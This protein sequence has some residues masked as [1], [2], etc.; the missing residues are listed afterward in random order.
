MSTPVNFDGVENRFVYDDGTVGWLDTDGV[1]RF[2]FGWDTMLKLARQLCTLTTAYA[3]IIR[4]VFA[5]SPPVL[6]ALEV[7]IIACGVLTEAAGTL[8]RGEVPDA[9]GDFVDRTL[10]DLQ[11]VIDKFGGTT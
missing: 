9:S 11:Q 7:A 6:L 2:K 8:A 4:R 1:P 3:P 10:A 5:D